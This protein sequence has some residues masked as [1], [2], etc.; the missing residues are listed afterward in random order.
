MSYAGY[1]NYFGN[2]E[3]LQEV[4]V[5]PILLQKGSTKLALYGL[6]NVKDERLH[7]L[8][9]AGKVK[10][11]RPKVNQN[12]WF[13]MFV[14]HQN[15]SVS[16]LVS[17]LSYRSRNA[18]SEKNYIP[19]QFLPEFLELVFWGHEHECRIDPEEHHG[20]H[21]TQPGSSVATSLCEGESAIK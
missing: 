4:E 11:L 5:V 18:H 20:T 10:F 19:D 8:F 17:L 7:R 1:V 16:P 13:N 14:I 15:R 3:C 9:K 21:I 2:Y 6:G 12:E